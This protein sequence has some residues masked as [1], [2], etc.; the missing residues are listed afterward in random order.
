MKFHGEAKSVD[1]DTA[2]GL[3]EESPPQLL[4]EFT[5]EN[6]F[7]CDETGLFYRCLPDRT[8]WIQDRKM[9]RWKKVKRKTHC[10]RNC[11]HDWRKIASTGNQQGQES[12]LPQAPQ[13]STTKL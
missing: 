8:Q 13:N 6:I 10:T 4:K 11:K 12:V 9:C 1:Q 3:A 5:A 7:N 2:N